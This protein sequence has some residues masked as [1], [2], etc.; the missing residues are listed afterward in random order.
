MVVPSK[1][2]AEGVAVPSFTIEV[3]LVLHGSIRMN[4]KVVGIMP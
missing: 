1:N 2:E 4:L 3:G